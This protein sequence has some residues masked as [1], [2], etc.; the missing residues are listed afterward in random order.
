MWLCYKY[1]MT[2]TKLEKLYRSITDLKDLELSISED[3]QTK[4]NQLE[5]KLIKDEVLPAISDEI[6]PIIEHIQRDL[7]LVIDYHPNEPLSVSISRKRNILDVID[8]AKRIEPD[9]KVEHKDGGKH[10]EPSKKSPKT[11]LVVY[12]SDGTFIQEKF[13][14]DTFVEAIKKAGLMQVRNLN[15]KLARVPL[16]SNTLDSKYHSAQKTVGNGLYIITH[17]GNIQKKNILDKI[18]DMLDL[19]W[20]VEIIE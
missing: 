11:G 14:A 9:A 7:V 4:L 17:S 3:M 6:G 12:L 20:R 5:E 13:A 18:S 2:M 1:E 16:V 10:K 19:G 15:L 8:D